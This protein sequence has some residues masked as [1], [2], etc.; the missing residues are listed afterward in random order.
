MNKLSSAQKITL[1][2]MAGIAINVLCAYVTQSFNL[3]IYMD[4]CGT[5]FIAA[6]GGYVPGIA[7]GFFTNLFGSLYDNK[8]IYFNF[9]SISI[10]LIT[11]FLCRRGYYEKFPKILL[12]IPFTV[13]VVSFF[14]ALIE[15]FVFQSTNEFTLERFWVHYQTNFLQ[16]IPDKSIAVLTAFI[17]LKFVPNDLREKFEL[18]GKMQSPI[19]AEMR[20]KIREDSKF[21]RSLRTK[22]IFNLLTITVLVTFS[23]SAIS[24]TIF[25]A[26]IISD[27][28]KIADGIASMIVAEI[29]TRRVDEFLEKGHK[30]AGYNDVEWKLRRIRA[31]NSDIK[32]LY[33][34]KIEEDGCHV[35][36]DLETADV[37]PTQPGDIEEFDESFMSYVPDLLAGRPIPPIKNNDTYGHLLTVYKPVYDTVGNCVC[38]AGIDFSMDMIDDYVELFI[39]RIIALFSG[40]L[41]FIVALVLTFVENNII[42][43]VNTMAHCAKNFAYDS[44]E[45]RERNIEH[46][47]AL[48]IKTN[49]EIEN[50]YSAF[51]K[52]TEDS[53]HYFENFKRAKL[54]AAVMDELAHKDAMT[55]IKNKAAYNKDTAKLEKDIA[56]GVAHFCIIMIDINFLKKI[57]DTYGHE[58]GDEY[59][60]NACKLVCEVFGKDNVYRVGGDEFV[61]ILDGDKVSTCEDKVSY[62]RA[63]IEKL[64]A[65][66][67][68]QAWKK[69]SAAVGVA[70]YQSGVD[71]NSEEVFKR[72]DSDMYKNKL[73]MK[74]VRKD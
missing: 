55:G 40:A 18:L 33:V 24:Y 1:I 49:D 27:R 68:L 25:R 5:V 64:R 54:E 26:T 36:F 47:K 4:T 62:L 11:A 21:I 30:A 71:K 70:Y 67:K 59:L 19:S 56:A 7:V 57:N 66:D 46:I 74:A 69:V 32:F 42:L 53:M 13:L 65:D 6:L 31:S 14:G 61:V 28:E 35:V 9:V 23:I 39:A 12:T 72:A 43:P 16:E 45:A 52:T 73:A 51:V 41:V 22:M 3:P 60:I 48:D 63:M 58:R 8:E 15:E 37:E 20:C 44:E 10:A 17:M 34:Y 29:D 2:C 38:Y 50:L